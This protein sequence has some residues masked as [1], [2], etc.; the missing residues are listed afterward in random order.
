MLVLADSKFLNSPA[1]ADDDDEEAEAGGVVDGKDD[2]LAD[3]F[4]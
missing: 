1:A 4:P 3:D 2:G